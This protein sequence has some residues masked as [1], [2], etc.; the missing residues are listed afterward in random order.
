TPVGTL[1][2]GGGNHPGVD[3]VSVEAYLNGIA[4][5]GSLGFEWRMVSAPAGSQAAL[6][7]PDTA[8]AVIQPDRPGTYDLQVQVRDR[9]AVTSGRHASEHPVVLTARPRSE[10]HTSELQS[11]ENLVCRLLL[12]KKNKK[13]Q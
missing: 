9:P 6:T 5:E 1:W 8:S 11:R 7:A 4:L 13:K 12:E 10:E 3:R 2:V